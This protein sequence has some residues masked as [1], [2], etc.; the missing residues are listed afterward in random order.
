MFSPRYGGELYP[1]AT[2]QHGLATQM[3][4]Q[5]SAIYYGREQHPWARDIA[6]TSFTHHLHTALA[7]TAAV[8]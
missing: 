3:L 6:T 8:I 2:P 7:N 4:K 5:L 1:V